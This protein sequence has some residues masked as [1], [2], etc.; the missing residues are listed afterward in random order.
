MSKSPSDPFAELLKSSAEQPETR[1][2]F[3]RLVPSIVTTDSEAE[4]TQPTIGASVTVSYG[5]EAKTVWLPAAAWEGAATL[6]RQT[7]THCRAAVAALLTVVHANLPGNEPVYLLLGELISE[8]EHDPY[9]ELPAYG[10]D[11]FDYLWS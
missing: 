7:P 1:P 6:I 3:N 9:G 8:I 10:H 4:K 2:L 5:R 11:S